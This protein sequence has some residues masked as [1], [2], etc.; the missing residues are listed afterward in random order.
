ML[1]KNDFLKNFYSVYVKFTDIFKRKYL[2]PVRT[3][4]PKKRD[5]NE[6]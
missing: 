4:P 1:C 5:A 2:K 3:K 6:N